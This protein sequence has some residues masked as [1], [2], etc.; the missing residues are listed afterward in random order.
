MALPLLKSKCLLTHR[1]RTVLRRLLFIHSSTKNDVNE[2]GRGGSMCTDCGESN[3]CVEPWTLETGPQAA[4]R[5]AR[6]AGGDSSL[7]AFC[8]T[9][10]GKVHTDTHTDNGQKITPPLELG[11]LRSP[12][13]QYGPPEE[14]LSLLRHASCA[15]FAAIS[16]LSA[17]CEGLNAFYALVASAHAS[18][19]W[20]S[21]GYPFRPSS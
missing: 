4:R 10:G 7:L 18:A 14:T 8:S 2:S 3:L 20:A 21:I 6:A 13:V 17:L 1:R 16:D 15:R 9:R 19:L 11:C 5:R 12:T